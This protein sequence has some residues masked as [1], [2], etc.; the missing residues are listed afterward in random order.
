[1]QNQQSVPPE[2]SL[3]RKL[4]S[5]WNK[6]INTNLIKEKANQ[7]INSQ[8]L[9]NATNFPFSQVQ[10]SKSPTESMRVYSNGKVRL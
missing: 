6:I 1:M 5:N 10:F 2:S 8:A 9:I 3:G 7:G 4:Y